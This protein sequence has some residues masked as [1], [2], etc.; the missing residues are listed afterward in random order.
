MP[1][2][3]EGQTLEGPRVPAESAQLPR[4][5]RVPEADGAVRTRGG[6]DARLLGTEGHT[7]DLAVVAAQGKAIL[8]QPARQRSRVPD[9]DGP[10]VAGRD[11]PVAVGGEHH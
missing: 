1:C 8:L 4:G 3:A 7:V 5:P 6:D 9:A 2:P 11:E 10:V